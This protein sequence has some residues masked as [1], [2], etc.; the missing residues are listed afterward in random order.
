MKKWGVVSAVAIVAVVVVGAGY[1]AN[2]F[3]KALPAVEPAKA[4]TF[5][6]EQIDTGANLVM[7]GRLRGMPHARGK[8]RSVGRRRPADTLRH[9]LF[10]EHHPG[11]RNRDRQLVLCRL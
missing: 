6:G 7:L 10:D 4:S 1:V 9:D 8:A 11:C 3:P 2:V 5:A